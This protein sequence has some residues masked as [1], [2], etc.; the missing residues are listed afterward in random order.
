MP[1]HES[2]MLVFQPEEY[3]FDKLDRDVKGLRD[4]VRA[5]NTELSEL[6]LQLKLVVACQREDEVDRQNS[7]KLT[8]LSDIQDG[9][10]QEVQFR[11]SS[12]RKWIR[13]QNHYPEDISY[14]S[15]RYPNALVYD[16][17]EE[18]F[19]ICRVNEL[20]E[21]TP[22]RLLDLEERVEILEV[23]LTSRINGLQ[24]RFAAT[25]AARW[26]NAF[27]REGNL[28]ISDPDGEI[29]PLYSIYTGS[30]IENFP[31]TARQLAALDDWEVGRILGALDAVFWDNTKT[32]YKVPAEAMQTLQIF[33]GVSKSSPPLLPEKPSSA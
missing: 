7:E 30:P 6:R 20:P 10:T 13:A 26:K 3:D 16:P 1:G 24:Q 19:H 11:S 14:F 32:E 21:M 8:S 18:S 9:E 29:S 23:N 25:S 5:K 28:R 12:S 17:Q 15:G 27:V 4:L 2:D 22:Q 31:K 33:A